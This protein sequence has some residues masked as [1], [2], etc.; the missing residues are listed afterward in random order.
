M[1]PE[2][3]KT[4]LD[5]LAGQLATLKIMLRRLRA[6]G[7]PMSQSISERFQA[8]AKLTEPELVALVW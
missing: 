2:Q 7:G 3:E 1:T 8:I 6:E 4:A 5:R